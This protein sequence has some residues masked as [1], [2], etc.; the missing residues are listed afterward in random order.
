[1]QDHINYK[2]Q[3]R[4]EKW[5]AWGHEEYDYDAR[6]FKPAEEKFFCKSCQTHHNISSAKASFDS[7][8]R[9]QLKCTSCHTLTKQRLNA[10][11]GAK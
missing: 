11:K 7:L 9:K 4:I 1:M 6:Y 8:N 5:F 2:I 10:L 3:Q